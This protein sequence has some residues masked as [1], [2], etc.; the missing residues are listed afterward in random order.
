[1]DIDSSGSDTLMAHE[2]LDGHKID[3]V[4][5]EMGP[6]SVAESM[7]GDPFGPAELFFVI[8]DMPGDKESVDRA[9]GVSLFGEEPAGRPAACKPVLCKDIQGMVREDGKPVGP[10]LAM[11]DIDPLIPALDIFIPEIT[12]FAYTETGRIHEGDHGFDFDV[13]D[14]LNKGPGFFLGR[15]IRE[16]NVKLPHGEL[17][18]IPGFM[19]DI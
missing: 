2:C 9:R 5:V 19:K 15:H 10:V 7:A 13:R 18:G 14:G 12:D 3:P 4:F 17:G 1:M 16:I 11:P 8:M 6:E